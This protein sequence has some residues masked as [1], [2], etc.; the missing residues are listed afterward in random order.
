MLFKSECQSVQ[1]HFPPCFQ[2][3]CAYVK[4]CLLV[5]HVSDPLRCLVSFSFA[6]RRF[7]ATQALTVVICSVHA[8]QTCNKRKDAMRYV[9]IKKTYNYFEHWLPDKY[10][11]IRQKFFFK[12]VRQLLTETCD[13]SICSQQMLT[14]MVF[15]VHKKLSQARGATASCSISEIVQMKV[16]KIQYTVR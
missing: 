16:K 4:V 8:H 9:T 3:L 13:R 12:V 1:A 7:Q 6:H 5:P 10:Y 14:T 11:A 2:L 15:P